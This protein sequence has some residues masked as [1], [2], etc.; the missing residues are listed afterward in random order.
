MTRLQDA[1]LAELR[2]RRALARHARS[3]HLPVM[4]AFHLRLALTARKALRRL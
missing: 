3:L 1:L 2:D 4:R